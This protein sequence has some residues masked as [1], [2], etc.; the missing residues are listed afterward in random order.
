MLV[1]RVPGANG[2]RSHC[3]HDKLCHACATT[4]M[5]GGEAEWNCPSCHKQIQTVVKDR[6]FSNTVVEI[7]ELNARAAQS[8]LSPTVAGVCAARHVD[9]RE[10]VICQSARSD[11]TMSQ[12]P[13]SAHPFIVARSQKQQSSSQFSRTDLL[14]GV[15]TPMGRSTLKAIVRTGQTLCKKVILFD[16]YGEADVQR[17]RRIFAKV[18]D[19]SHPNIMRYYD[20]I[21]ED[22]VSMHVYMEYA[23]CERTLSSLIRTLGN[24]VALSTV[25]AWTRQLVEGVQFLHR[26]GV[27]N[28]AIKG[29]NIFVTA[30]SVLKIAVNFNCSHVDE[31]E[32]ATAD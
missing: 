28:R 29:D 27:I 6:T 26:N 31:H 23:S 15:S 2:A 9:E 16:N 4:I 12:A 11:S 14:S 13:S 18:D 22:D 8:R 7:L 24:D 30:D 32:N 1:L 10:T 25:R 19:L 20:C 5:S 17:L 3:C 21:E